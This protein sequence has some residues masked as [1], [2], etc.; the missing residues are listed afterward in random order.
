MEQVKDKANQ[1]KAPPNPSLVYAEPREPDQT[2][3]RVYPCVCVCTSVW[4]LSFDRYRAALAN[5]NHKLAK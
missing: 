2:C 3:V 5:P 1:R 4:L